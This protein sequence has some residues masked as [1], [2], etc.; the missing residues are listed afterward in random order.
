MRSPTAKLNNL[1][2]GVF[3]EI[4]KRDSNLQKQTRWALRGT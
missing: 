4:Q 3:G 2:D 1:L